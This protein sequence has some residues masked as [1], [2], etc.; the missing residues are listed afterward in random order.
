MLRLIT[1]KSLLSLCFFLVVLFSCNKDGH[2]VT[3]ELIFGTYSYIDCSGEDCVETYKLGYEELFEDTLDDVQH[4]NNLEFEKLSDEKFEKAEVLRT[5]IPREILGLSPVTFGS[6]DSEG[7]GGIYLQIQN[8]K[9]HIDQD[10]EKVP[11]FLHEFVDE[12]L[13]LV[14]EL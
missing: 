12:V 1:T 7:Q 3:S 10:K 4:Y 6:P 14:E 9:F 8:R 5:I 2:K 13:L 11:D